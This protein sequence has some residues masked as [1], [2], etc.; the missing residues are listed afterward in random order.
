MYERDK[1]PPVYKLRAINDYEQNCYYMLLFY[2]MKKKKTQSYS[3]GG[4]DS[5][6]K[7]SYN[8]NKESVARNLAD[9]NT[10]TQF[11]W[12]YL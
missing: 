10:N 7:K 1:K 6:Q 8:G 2:F 5:N 12:N 9:I 3:G 11:S 4:D